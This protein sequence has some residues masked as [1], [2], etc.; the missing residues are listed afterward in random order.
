MAS[1]IAI[2]SALPPSK[3]TLNEYGYH[4]VKAFHQVSDDVEVLT[5]ADKVAVDYG[6]A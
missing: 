6:F 2:V 4:L 3:V 1:K 5:F